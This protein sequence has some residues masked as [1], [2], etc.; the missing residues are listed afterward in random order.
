MDQ[1]NNNDIYELITAYLGDELNEKG[2]NRINEWRRLSSL[3]EEEFQRIKNIWRLKSLLGSMESFDTKSAL[4]RFR[5]NIRS[6]NK[7]II[8][9]FQ[10]IASILILPLLAYTLFLVQA[11]YF[12]TKKSDVVWLHFQSIPGAITNLKLPDGT[13]VTLNMGSSI[14]YPSSFNEDTREVK[15]TGEAFF[16]VSHNEDCPFLVNTGEMN[17]KVLGTKF[18]VSNYEESE[19]LEVVL[20][21]GKVGL[22]KGECN[23]KTNLK[24]LNAGERAVYNKNQKTI[25]IDR[26]NVKNYIC[27]KEGILVFNDSPMQEVVNKLNRWFNVNIYFDDD[28]LNEYYFTATF[29]D[30]NL[31]QI[32]ELLK[33]ST[34]IDFDMSPRVRLSNKQ[35][36]KQRIKIINKK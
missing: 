35:Y 7:N 22:Y 2:I 18:N 4:E 21:S 30:E 16:D 17:V 12:P 1:D 28:R 20:E 25:A 36:K 15:L 33:L 34:P 26:V 14:D 23:N 27:W 19:S 5:S 8:R 32:L 13:N 6:S 29:V 3:N 11:E 31:D 9:I 10:R 24:L